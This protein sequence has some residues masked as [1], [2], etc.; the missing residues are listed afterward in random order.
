M[1]CLI[2]TLLLLV[3]CA[4]PSRW[5]RLPLAGQVT[6]NDESFNG[7]LVLRPGQGNRGPSVTCDVVDG[8]FQFS[9]QSGP[10][11][12]PHVA[13]LMLPAGQPAADQVGALTLTTEVPGDEPLQVELKF[14]L[15]ESAAE[16]A[17]AAV[18]TEASPIQK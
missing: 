2:C 18:S 10:V 4:E 1:R 7:A 9:R 6:L 5:D 12:G 15:D 11:A 3:G 16:S 13:M 14:I 8:R 17:P